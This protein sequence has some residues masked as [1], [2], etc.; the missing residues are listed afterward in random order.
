MDKYPPGLWA[1]T[2]CFRVVKSVFTPECEKFVLSRMQASPRNIK[3]IIIID[4]ITKECTCMIPNNTLTGFVNEDSSNSKLL[5][6]QVARTAKYQV[7]KTEIQNS[8]TLTIDEKEK[9]CLALS[10]LL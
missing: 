4:D 1:K 6:L 3:P 10:F 8:S 5:C 9:K 7:E 2:K